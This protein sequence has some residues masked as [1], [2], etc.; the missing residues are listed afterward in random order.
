MQEFD[1]E[2]DAVVANAED[3]EECF[4]Y[5]N[6]VE[7]LDDG[8]Q[9]SKFW[10]GHLQ[11]ADLI[12]RAEEMRMYL[13]TVRSEPPHTSFWDLNE[14]EVSQITANLSRAYT[15]RLDRP[16][17]F[18]KRLQKAIMTRFV[19]SFTIKGKKGL[20]KMAAKARIG[21]SITAPQGSPWT[22]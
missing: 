8:I 22:Q 12:R 2:E 20:T 9:A 6:K 14:S 21:W 16:L 7:S 10:F 11:S 5:L 17:V 19:C 13:N 18:K 15:D 4:Y 3:A 1:T